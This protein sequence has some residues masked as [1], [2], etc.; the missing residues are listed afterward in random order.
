M[1]AVRK[2]APDPGVH[3]HRVGQRGDVS[4]GLR[5]DVGHRVDERHLGRQE[6]VGGPLDQLGGD[7]V[8]GQQRDA[9]L[10]QRPVDLAD[11]RL[12][13]DA[14]HA[15]HDPVRT[16]GVVDGAALA[17]ELGIPGDLDGVPRGRPAAQIAD[18]PGGGAGR[19]GGLADDQRGPGQVRGERGDG[20]EDLRQ[21]VAGMVGQAR[22]ADAEK[23]HGAEPRRLLEAGREPEPPRLDVARQQVVEAGLE[24]PGAAGA[25][26]RHLVRV[27]VDAEHLMPELGHARGVRRTE[28]PAPD[29][30]QPHASEGT[31]AAWT[32]GFGVMN[33]AHRD[34]LVNLVSAM[35]R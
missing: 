21:V 22:G 25:Q 4:A 31:R 9:R 6:R 13:G 23:V 15:D 18:Q 33:A 26:Q 14:G 19:D 28:V 12:G 5:A 29:H 11:G 32:G 10:G 7:R 27:D 30:R 35:A 16:E 1:P 2:R 24:E 34:E 20:A 8:G 3:A 17:Q